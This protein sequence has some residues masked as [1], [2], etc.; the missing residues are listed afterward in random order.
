MLRSPTPRRRAFTLVE[1]LVVIAIIAILIGLLLP[2][3]QKVRE[4]AARTQCINNLKQIGLALH[5]YES[6]Q[7]AFPTAGANGAVLGQNPAPFETF[8]W[9][10]QIL[11]Y[12][13]QDSLYQIGH[14]YGAWWDP[15]LNEGLVEIP[16]KM[17]LCPSRSSRESMPMPWGSVYKLTDYAG[18]MCEWGNEAS[19]TSAPNPNEMRAFQ[20]IIAKGGHIRTDNPALTVRYN[21]VRMTDVKDGLSN[22]IAIMEKAAMVNHWQPMD[23][24]WWELPGWA[25]G[26]DWPTMRLIGNWVP[27]LND[28]DERPGWFYSSA[29]NHGRP[30]EF[31]FGS[32]H[33]TIVNA[34]FGDGS[35][36]SLNKGMDDCGNQYWSDGGCVLYH[37]GGRQD[38]WVS[39]DY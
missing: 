7:H 5:N 16:V 22:T 6:T 19:S 39:N 33:P 9:P 35:V 29:G 27:L 24:D 15:Q 1:L 20:G 21:P 25:E 12:M 18:V 31:G 23:W 14:Q 26:C 38:G 30:A 2:A 28:T 32:N 36:H 3:V 34:V 17:Y 37:L 8:G 13:E 4:A 11:P 10:F